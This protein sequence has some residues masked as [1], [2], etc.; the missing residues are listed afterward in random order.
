[1]VNLAPETAVVT[2][3]VA[4][5]SIRRIGAGAP[6]TDQDLVA[7]EAPLEVFL[8][9]H[10][11][12]SRAATPIPMGVM[13]RTPGDDDDLVR[14]MLVAE[15]V[16]RST[17]SVLDIEHRQGVDERGH[18]TAIATA[19]LAPD[20]DLDAFSGARAG[21]SSSACG[22]C[23]RLAMLTVDRA[24]GRAPDVPAIAWSLIARLPA[25]LAVGQTVFA[26]TGGLHAAAL[27]DPTGQLRAL[28]EDVGRHNA[29]DKVVGAALAL[30][31]VP[32]TALILAVSGRVA[33]E[34]VQKAAMAGVCAIV[35]V[36]APSSLAVEAARA[37]G[38]TLVGFARDGRFNVYTGHDRIRE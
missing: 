30:G 25:A 9:Q 38:L 26:E 29:V 31:L 1:M 33:F 8:T 37:A 36:G 7:V 19:L 20:A 2:D 18:A 15:G 21:V 27:F 32:S 6:R 4:I 11:T 28:R 12:T 23:G 17:A 5:A 10:I 24:G 14:G 13:M 16:I 22:L 3:R 34:I 35:A